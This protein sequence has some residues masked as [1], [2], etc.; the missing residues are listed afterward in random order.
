MRVQ[1]TY[2]NQLG[3]PV[4]EVNVSDEQIDV[5]IDDAFSTSTRDN[6]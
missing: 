4:L 6:I 2:S 1:G 5:S 3:K